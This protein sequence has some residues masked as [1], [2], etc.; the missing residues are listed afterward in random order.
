M[1]PSKFNKTP[2]SITP[3]KSV[4]LGSL[5]LLILYGSQSTYF[6]LFFLL[7]AVAVVSELSHLGFDCHK[8]AFIR[9]QRRAP[10]PPSPPPAGITGGKKY[11]SCSFHVAFLTCQFIWLGITVLK[12]KR[13]GRSREECSEPPG[14]GQSSPFSVLSLSHSLHVIIIIRRHILSIYFR[15]ERTLGSQKERKRERVQETRLPLKLIYGQRLRVST[16]V[17]A[18]DA[19]AILRPLLGR[20]K[21]RDGHTL[22]KRRHTRKKTG[23]VNKYLTFIPRNIC[24]AFFSDYISRRWT[25]KIKSYRRT[26]SWKSL[27]RNIFFVCLCLR[28]LLDRPERAD[29]P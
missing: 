16:P 22:E 17:V 26:W 27:S 24:I 29:F 7:V 28:D 2:S 19:T 3:Y 20:R 6:Q 14:P 25:T 15:N 18:S 9:R 10:L 12:R 11:L 5:F 23:I 4:Q 8:S 13:K 21:E 1:L